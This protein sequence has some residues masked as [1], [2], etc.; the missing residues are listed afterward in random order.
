M[1]G[2]GDK[3]VCVDDRF[4]YDEFPVKEKASLEKGRIYTVYSVFKASYPSEVNPPR[5]DGRVLVLAETINPNYPNGGFSASRFRKLD[6]EQFRDMARNA[7]KIDR[8]DVT[9]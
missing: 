9:V 5:H 4:R 8:K 2:P 3:V 7:G 1:I 6:I